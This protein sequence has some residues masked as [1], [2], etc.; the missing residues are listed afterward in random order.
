MEIEINVSVEILLDVEG[1]TLGDDGHDRLPH[2]GLE[3]GF[4]TVE[5]EVD[6]AL[7]HTGS[8]GHVGELRRGEPALAEHLERG[9]HDLSRPGVFPTLPAGLGLTLRWGDGVA[10][11][12]RSGRIVSY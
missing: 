11:G 6:G 10:H 12:A 8:P 3:Q 2:H 9:G 1:L 7:S 4:L 5:V